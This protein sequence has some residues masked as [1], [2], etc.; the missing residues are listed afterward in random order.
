MSKGK[1]L[2]SLED[3]GGFVYSTNES[4]SP[5]SEDV[6]NDIPASEQNLEAHLEKKGRGGKVVVIIKGFRS[7]EVMEWSL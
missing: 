1:K 5:E 3:L 4:F 6:E 2:S 7:L